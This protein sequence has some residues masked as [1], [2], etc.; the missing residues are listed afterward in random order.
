[1]SRP[2]LSVRGLVVEFRP[3]GGVVRAVDGVDLEVATGETLGVVGESGSGKTVTML[4]TLGLLPPPPYCTVTGEVLLS[5]RNVLAMSRRELRDIRGREVGMVF[6]DPMTS[7]HPSLRVV[8]QVAEAILVHDRRLSRAQARTR[9]LEQLERVGV[10]HPARRLRDYP[11]QWSG[12]MRQRAMLAM[13][14]SNAP[15]LLVADEPTTALDVTIQA[16]ILDV[17]RTARDELGASTV[18]ITHDLGVVAELADRVSVM[19]AG[20]VV[21]AAGV[22]QLFAAP[23]HRHTVTLLT[24]LPRLDRP[25][26]ARPVAPLPRPEVLRTEDLVTHYP[27]PGRGVV[28]AVDGVSLTLA[29]GQ[30][31]GL[32]G[33]SGCGKSTLA[34]TVLRLVEPTS[35]R[36][37]LRGEDLTAA[38][39][40]RLRRLRR[41]LSMVFQDPYASLNPRMTIGEIVAQ[42][43][44]IAGC[45]RSSGGQARVAELLDLVGLDPHTSG[46]LPA[47]FSGGQRQRIAI[48]RALALNPGVL[49]LDEP[50]S[51][52]DVSIQAQVM[53][54][55]DRLQRELGL[56]YLFIA[57]D[58]ALVRQISDRVAVMYLGVIVETGTREQ[59]YERP[60]HPYTQSLLSAVP[61]PDPARRGARKRIPLTG[62]VPDPVAP[63]AGCRFR[64]RCWKARDDCSQVVPELVVRNGTDHPSACLYPERLD[65]QTAVGK[66]R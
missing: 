7:L 41:S 20:R 11:H 33:E 22:R 12:G 30:T 47:E 3:R 42:P 45:Y 18:L 61:A 35:G 17:L 6:Q 65:V 51:S 52:L 38:T 23:E 34:R 19:Q 57:H 54:L 8:D 50:V 32:V 9:A 10:A 29:A 27:S 46:R 13:A 39:G 62:E 43:L 5:G 60:V 14:I 26:P 55:L 24:A 2:L 15:A 49:V 56:A 21:E 63:P 58:L 1:M 31:L 16:Q 44:R 25:V 37:L 53:T 4:A 59:V 28:H 36:V 64:T 66:L 48:A 40:R